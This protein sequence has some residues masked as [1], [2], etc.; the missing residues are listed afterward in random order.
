MS[1]TELA[2]L[3]AIWFL[4][5]RIQSDIS[6]LEVQFLDAIQWAREARK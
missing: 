5:R 3:M 6:K 4:G 2:H 1:D